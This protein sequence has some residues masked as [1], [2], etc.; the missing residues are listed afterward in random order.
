MKYYIDDLYMNCFTGTTYKDSEDKFLIGYV[1]AKEDGF[2]LKDV[3]TGQSVKGQYFF[4]SITNLRSHKNNGADMALSYMTDFGSQKPTVY[5]HILA[6]V[7]DKLLSEKSL[8]TKQ[9]KLIKNII[10]NQ[11]I[12][13][14]EN[15]LKKKGIAEETDYKRE[16]VEAVPG[17]AIV[18]TKEQYK[19]M[20]EHNQAEENYARLQNFKEYFANINDQTQGSSE[21]DKT[22]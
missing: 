4:H 1:N 22:L 10:S 19:E 20:Q 15:T 16:S 11:V 21:D 13:N 6:K 8:D 7:I 18:I 12:K 9:I 3:T 17:P 2:R 14:H 5:Q